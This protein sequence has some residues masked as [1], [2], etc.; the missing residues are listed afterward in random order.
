MLLPILIMGLLT[1][2]LYIPPIQ[3]YAVSKI[4]SYVKESS[5]YDVSID[6]FHLSFP[7]K[8]TIN[9]FEVAKGDTAIA[10]GEQIETSI[11]ILPL[12]KG[13][14]EVDYLSID[15]TSANTHNLI[16]GIKINGEIG[17]LRITARNITPSEERAKISHLHI[18]DSDINIKLGKKQEEKEDSASSSFGWLFTLK[19]CH[20]SNVTAALY[21]PSDTTTLGIII[22][23]LNISNAKIAP[24]TASYSAEDLIL[25][26]SSVAYNSGTQPDSV[27]PLNHIHLQNI[28]LSAN[29][30]LLDSANISCNIESLSVTQ[31]NGT[32]ITKASAKIATERKNIEINKLQLH[33]ANNS[34]IKGKA[35]IPID[36]FKK[37]NSG[38]IT[39]DATLYVD[40]RDLRSI[41]THQQ[42]NSINFLPDSL[43][44]TS[45]SLSA[46]QNSIQIDTLTADIPKLLHI[47]TSGKLQDIDKPN[48]TRGEIALKGNI[49]DVRCIIEQQIMP[50]SIKK[51]TLRIMGNASIENQLCNIILRMRPN[52]G[53]A[54]MFG[55]YNIGTKSYTARARARNI[56]IEDILPNI[57][58]RGLT[59]KLA[60][61]GQGTDIFAD[62][63]YYN[64]SLNIDTLLIDSTRLSN[65]TLS[66]KQ[67]NKQSYIEA[68][69][70]NSTLTMSANIDSRL[71]RNEIKIG[72]H[73]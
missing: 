1:V 46:T 31:K 25:S 72:A 8:A 48:K 47:E 18:T 13:D 61:E 59:M 55:S 57:P 24:A 30:I 42:Y 7:I 63:T 12:L 43:L 37:N 29:N 66:A 5:G 44:Q 65:I 10:K 33:T 6:A 9:N 40:K 17:H 36:F 60:A 68:A 3:N 50:D 52:S 54:T 58:L 16:D 15:N 39:A 56:N 62:S 35:N 38:K 34:F 22:D 53:S 23:A 41:L 20:L 26:K 21:M 45:L 70:N 32:K 27:A 11:R 64:C 71:D 51:Q 69:S 2:A 49:I 4:C 14:I 73:V 19:K 67:K 28:N